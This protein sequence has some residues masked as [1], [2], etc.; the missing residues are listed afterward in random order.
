MTRILIFCVLLIL[1]HI[2]IVTDQ[3]NTDGTRPLI[4]HNVGAGPRLEDM[5][6]NYKVTGHYR[7]FP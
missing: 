5:L 4:V 7:Y 1:P 3:K 2:G 6:F